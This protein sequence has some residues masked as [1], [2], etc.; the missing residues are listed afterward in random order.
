MKLSKT[1]K[2]VFLSWLMLLWATGSIKKYID[3]STNDHYKNIKPITTYEDLNGKTLNITPLISAQLAKS[4]T[5]DI[6][7]KA[8]HTIEDQ[9]ID[10]YEQHSFPLPQ[11]QTD[12]KSLQSLTQLR[13]RNLIYAGDFA[14]TGLEE[15]N[16]NTDKFWDAVCASAIRA[17]LRIMNTRSPEMRELFWQEE[18]HTRLSQQLL[19]LRWWRSIISGVDDRE[20]FDNIIA[21][22]EKYIKDNYNE[23]IRKNPNTAHNH[24]NL[25][26]TDPNSH[27]HK[28]LQELSGSKAGDF[29]TAIYKGSSFKGEARKFDKNATH[30]L[31]S[32]GKQ[33]QV[34]NWYADLDFTTDDPEY[35]AFLQADDTEKK[36]ILIYRLLSLRTIR[37]DMLMEKGQQKAFI[38]QIMKVFPRLINVSREFKK[39]GTNNNPINLVVRYGWTRVTHV[40]PLTK[41]EILNNIREHYKDKNGKFILEKQPRLIQKLYNK[42]LHSNQKKIPYNFRH[43]IW[44]LVLSNQFLFCDGMTPWTKANKDYHN[45]SKVYSQIDSLREKTINLDKA[46]TYYLSFDEFDHNWD[47]K[48]NNN[49]INW[50]RD[51]TLDDIIEQL[52]DIE[53]NNLYEDS[54]FSINQTKEKKKNIKDALWKYFSMLWIHS[55][56]PIVPIVYLSDENLKNINTLYTS[57]QWVE[58]VFQKESQKAYHDYIEKKLSDTKITDIQR[59]GNIVFPVCRW[60]DEISITRQICKYIDILIDNNKNMS[61]QIRLWQLTREEY[62]IIY[63]YISSWISFPEIDK[64]TKK[65]KLEVNQRVQINLWKIITLLQ[66]YHEFKSKISVDLL[67]Q[68]EWSVLWQFDNVFDKLKTPTGVRNLIKHELISEDW[69]GTWFFDIAKWRSRVKM[70]SEEFDLDDRNTLWRYLLRKIN[71]EWN[72]QIRIENFTNTP[73]N[74]K[75]IWRVSNEIIQNKRINL[76]ESQI[77]KLQELVDLCETTYIHK[78]NTKPFNENKKQ[79]KHLLSDIINISSKDREDP[80]NIN[81]LTQI[82][83]LTMLNEKAQLR[84][85]NILQQ[86]I[87]E[88]ELD[89]QELAFVNHFTRIAVHLWQADSDYTFKIFMSNY[90]IQ[91]WIHIHT[92]TNEEIDVFCWILKKLNSIKKKEPLDLLGKIKRFFYKRDNNTKR[93]QERYEQLI[94]EWNPHNNPYI[95]DIIRYLD[96][97]NKQTSIPHY[98][99]LRSLEYDKNNNI[100]PEWLYISTKILESPSLRTFTAHLMEI[101]ET[102]DSESAML[103]FLF[104]LLSGIWLYKVNKKKST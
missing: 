99:T 73:E 55:T 22:Y 69:N 27:Y 70:M 66:P 95:S 12:S 57:Y 33:Y 38:R 64:E 67:P 51:K 58:K 17:Q 86:S 49:I 34:F 42:I 25:Y 89:I 103:W 60:D 43:F 93:K 75:E 68:I 7:E 10:E 56:G 20:K 101:P 88:K 45:I 30:S 19:W 65:P 41:E 87:W 9:A 48:I 26:I 98:N 94:Q 81:M 36:V 72:T 18:K 23:D 44:E 32:L 47:K 80:E 85:N 91:K 39:D 15:F 14:S 24:Y 2:N 63:K 53:F 82:K 6:S 35:N 78:I 97:N 5:K 46:H 71:S 40:Y 28:L 50:K 8:Q 76:P 54:N 77:N 29:L 31:L 59:Q 96:P 84:Y 61:Q 90:L 1:T 37:K 3:S 4:L 11:Y 74:I 62:N 104:F 100:L 21:H 83:L 16:I 52:T 102:K 92:T 79:V 13:D